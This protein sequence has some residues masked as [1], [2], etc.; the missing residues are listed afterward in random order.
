[1]RTRSV[2]VANAG[3]G[4]TYLL[5]NRLIGWMLA[6]RRAT[7]HAHPERI[8]AVTFTR[9]AA[10]EILERVLRHLAQGA[11]DDAR[12]REFAGTTQCADATADEYAAILRETIDAM[13]RLS[14][15]TIDGFFM[16]LAAAFAPELGLPEGWG[17]AEDDH[18]AEQLDAAV[19][20]VVTA[21]PARAGDLARR[22]ASGEPQVDVQAGITG[23]LK[24]PLAIA[25]SAS[26]GADP[27]APW[28][29]LLADGVR[30]FD[31]ARRADRDVVAGAVDA[32]RRAA[33]P[34]T[35]AGKPNRNWAGAL[36]PA[37]RAA[38][39][40]DWFGVLES[41]MLQA[42]HSTGSYSGV[43]AEPAVVDAAA[44]LVPHAL[45]CIEQVVR[46]RIE[47]TAELA[48]LVDAALWARRGEDGLFGFS[49]VT[50]LVARAHALAG[51]GAAAMR[52]RLDREV[53]DIALDE[54]QDTSP[55]QWTAIEPLVDEVL[56]TGGRRFLVV[57][58]PKQSIYAWRGGTPALLA[59]V[60]R[61]PGLDAEEPL[62]VSYRSSPVVMDFVNALFGGL[63]STIAGTP[64]L[65][66]AVSEGP[67]AFAAAGLPVPPGCDRAPVLRALDGWT[68]VEH[69]SAPHLKGMPGAVCA[70]R[71]AQ[72]GAEGIA[73]AV[74]GIV[75][76]RAALRPD[77]TIAV[78]V[79][80]NDEIA[81]CAA[82]IRARGLPVSDE[83]RSELLDSPAVTGI[84]A[85]LRLAD[86]PADGIAHWLAT[87]EPCA[88]AFGLR[89]MEAFGG[90]HALRAEA[91][92][93]SAQVR[94]E[95]HALGLA[96]WVD[97]AID[98]LRGA[99]SQRD[100]ERLR[101]LSAMAHAAGPDEVA[102]PI[103]F[104][105]SVESRGARAPTGERIRVMTVHASKGLE[106]DEVVLGTLDAA[107]GSVS[108]GQG[109]WAVLSPDPA[110]PP[111]AVAPVL[112][113]GLLE[114]SALLRAF[115]REAEVEQARDDVSVLYVAVT[116]AKDALHLVCAPPTKS[117]NVRLTPTWLMR[118]S[119]ERFEA[120]FQQPPLDGGPFWTMGD[121]T[122][123]VHAVAGGASVDD[124][125]AP[126]DAAAPRP[127]R[128]APRI[129]WVA[130]PGACAARPPSSHEG[131]GGDVPELEAEYAGGD[132]GAR[133]SLA[134]GWMERIEWLPADGRV[135]PALGSE[136][137]RAVAIEVGRPIDGAMADDVRALVERACAGSLGAALRPERYA[138]WGCESLAVR[139][140]FPYV[141]EVAGRMQ[142]GRMDRVVLGFRGGRVVR[143][144]VLDH[145]TG[146]AGLAGE[147][148]DSRIAP[149]R[150]QM[151][152][153]R[154]VVAAMFGLDPSAVSTVLLMLERGEAIPVADA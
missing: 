37:V 4:K 86:Q 114:H 76:D 130:R 113:Q 56:A 39:S 52:E 18:A 100:V 22:I 59:A 144:E 27:Q 38:E 35:K 135:D 81:A 94:G 29:A 83:G 28:R 15:S 30:I 88:A 72:G 133:G 140:E 142:R 146:A 119:L 118:L 73:Q 106:F 34:A 116:R 103:R 149:Y 108:G 66:T 24:T 14:I 9:K 143:A 138:A 123:G 92:R 2:V 21:D 115:R 40:G 101:Q 95:L 85:L 93:V 49:D 17:I 13:H 78:L 10:G 25:A 102:R 63:A 7:G 6:E 51:S 19:G 136:V 110:K 43:A 117:G 79:R 60:E 74:A 90:G 16:Q 45:A 129:E 124:G 47:A 67:A 111:V 112:S 145:K 71:A 128:A 55:A 50:L 147:A 137:H 141:A 107:M 41:T 105:R 23:V 12:R 75:A 97:R 1:M 153:Y 109:E 126:G 77:A 84:V 91:D 5:A 82:A 152:G 68:F 96:A 36:P 80:S 53:R 121:A 132:D 33:V 64:A 65:G 150:A 58:D 139:N 104:V 70:Y 99:C 148:L 89:P 154:R 26:M 122:L 31:G 134:H 8:L 20:A 131:S 3:S 69:R 127:V 87:R 120:A 62:A 61:L 44:V 32:L 151:A 46:A 11:L 125:A 42:V 98:A 54:F 48:Q 57:G